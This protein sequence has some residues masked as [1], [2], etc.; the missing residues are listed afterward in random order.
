MKNILVITSRF[1]DPPHGGDKLRILNICKNLSK[2][3]NIYLA[4]LTDD[5]I[6]TKQINK[7]F[8]FK[9]INIVYLSKF[10]SYLN[11]LL[12]IFSSRPLQVSY[13][14]STDFA[15][16]IN[17]LLDKIEFDIVICHLIRTAP[18]AIN[19]KGIK[20]L[21]MTDVISMN[22]K[23]L[24]ESIS[25][26]SISK[27]IYSYELKKLSAYE[28]SIISLF[29]KTIL[30]SSVDRNYLLRRLSPCASNI[31][32]L[33][34]GVD[35]PESTNF[36]HPNKRIIVFIGNMDTLQNLD[37]VDFFIREVF[38]E[39]KRIFPGLIFKIIGKISHSS[40]LRFE[41]FDGV[42][43]TG[44]V[45]SISDELKNASVG[46]CPMRFGAGIQNKVLEYMASSIPTVT[47]SLGY[48][49]LSALIDVDIFV[50]DSPKDFISKLTE[51]LSDPVAFSDVGAAGRRYVI[52]NHSWD[53]VLNGYINV[54]SS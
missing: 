53:K 2:E 34:N 54:S 9:E 29:S 5:Y 47:T 11:C 36:S 6:K 42:L 16:V 8:I 13:Y 27:L 12:G 50:V 15:L 23:R 10:K 44:A 45:N 22:Y 32:I 28:D 31:Q 37:A 43:V 40:R 39:L 4:A 7:N 46:V 25:G 21:E 18:Y 49:G 38:I 17:G 52:D 41:S 3:N 24:G 1:P 51:I 35:I 14:K 30:V 19:F 26:F 33:S 20:I 48:E